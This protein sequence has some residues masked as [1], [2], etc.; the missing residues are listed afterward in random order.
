[1]TFVECI[2]NF[3]F[4]DVGL[5]LPT[6]PEIGKGTHIADRQRGFLQAQFPWQMPDS[7]LF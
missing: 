4:F 7:G 2:Y 1:M 6:R 3:L 5:F